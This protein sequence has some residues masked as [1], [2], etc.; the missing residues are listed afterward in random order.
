LIILFI[1]AIPSIIFIVSRRNDNNLKEVG[2]SESETIKF[3][4]EETNSF[5]NIDILIES[6]SSALKYLYKSGKFPPILTNNFEFLASEEY[7]NDLMLIDPKYN[8]VFV[9]IGDWKIHI[10]EG[11]VS[12]EIQQGIDIYINGT[13][14][15]NARPILIKLKFEKAIHVYRPPF[16]RPRSEKR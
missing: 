2:P 7:K 3:F 8:G 13:I 10:Y 1:V 5:E 14:D 9:R 11:T 4:N 12:G 15:L 16:D 6:L